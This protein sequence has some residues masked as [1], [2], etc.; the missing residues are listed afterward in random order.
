MKPIHGLSRKI[1]LKMDPPSEED[2]RSSQARILD[3]LKKEG[4]PASFSPAALRQLYPL[5]ENA[6]WKV[7]VSLGWN[8]T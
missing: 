8:G 2:S 1:F 5:C 7:T 6:G 3:A 4:V